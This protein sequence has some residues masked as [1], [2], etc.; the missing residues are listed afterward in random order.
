MNLPREN[1]FLVPL[2]FLLF[3]SLFFQSC[4]TNIKT[5]F[6]NISIEKIKKRGKLVAITGFNAYSY[7][8]YKGRT[9]GFEYE[10]L[11]KLGDR[12]GV[13]V[14]VK[15][16]KD[17]NEMFEL[18]EKGEGDLIA[19]NL[20]VTSGRKE[21]VDFTTHLNTTHQVLVQ[22]KPKNWRKLTRDAINDSLIKNPIDL[23]YKT[24]YVRNASA[25]K[26]RMENLAEEIGGHID[27]IEAPDSVSTQELI[28]QVAEGKIEYTISDEN[29]A[30]LSSA[31][32]TNIDIGTHISFPQ[33]IAWAVKKGST[34]FLG[35]INTWIEE[36][37]TE[38]DYYVIY[39]R[40]YKYR[41]YYAARRG[42]KYFL[43]EGGEI[44]KYDNLFKIY[45]DSIN[46]D[47]KLLAS[48]VFQES[49]F[50]PDVQSWA[51]AVG[52]MQLLPETGKAHG[53]EDL[54]DVEQNIRA[55]VD[56]IKW[57]DK[58]WLKKVENKNERIKFILASYNIG[59][60]HIVDARKL[61]EKY[62]ADPNV[63]TDNVED[64]LLKKS[65]PKYY[66]D[67][68]VRNGYCNG[69]ETHAYVKNII[70]RYERYLQFI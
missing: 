16:S 24:V 54:L 41:S 58:F 4:N 17:I 25:Y 49:K 13:E 69:K 33:K 47:W 48:L 28:E 11:K 46:W 66:N 67:E 30:R 18:L 32:Y 63:W 14:E 6:E 10:L 40:Y 29:V 55:G 45:A 5:P 39:D 52:L 59:F 7:F 57:L 23:E 42:S 60:G 20:T 62:G 27:I 12:L 43:S 9:M 65:K 38:V 15:I 36:L 22:R 2:L 44:S 3:S 37:K 19:F 51:G 50:K 61:A 26:E 70:S 35:E 1:R 64:Y 68:V 56:Y 53:A 31:Y 34:D 8:I 21:K